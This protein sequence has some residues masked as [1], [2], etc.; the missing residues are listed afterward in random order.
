MVALPPVGWTVERPDDDGELEVAVPQLRFFGQ[1]D[2]DS[3]WMRNLR[4]ELSCVILRQ[5]ETSDVLRIGFAHDRK[6]R[7][8]GWRGQHAQRKSLEVLEVLGFF[9][10][11]GTSSQS[12][13]CRSRMTA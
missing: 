10:S 3:R 6:V 11:R 8:D 2:N 12:S 1:P 7:L 13:A 4:F 9:D 5:R